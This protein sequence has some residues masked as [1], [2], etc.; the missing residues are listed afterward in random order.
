MKCERV[1]EVILTDYIDKALDE[2][3]AKEIDRHILTCADCREF[4]SIAIEK[5]VK[6]FKKVQEAQA[7]SY[8]WERVKGRIAADH[9]VETKHSG[10]LKDIFWSLGRIPKPA[11]AFAAAAAVIIAIFIAWPTDHSRGA[12]AYLADQMDFMLKLDMVE[13]N[14]NG[15]FDTEIRTSA[16]SIL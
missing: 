10:I 6:P 5:A 7:P 16:D 9:T 14:G 1:Q 3:L 4:K 12:N 2:R 13:A 8:I 11:V 15:V